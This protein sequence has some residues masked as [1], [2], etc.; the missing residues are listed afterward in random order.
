MTVL[1]CVEELVALLSKGILDTPPLLSNTRSHGHPLLPLSSIHVVL[2]DLWCRTGIGLLRKRF[3][4]SQSCQC[5]RERRSKRATRRLM[6][7]RRDLDRTPWRT[8]VS[9]CGAHNA[10]MIRGSCAAASVAAR[11]FSPHCPPFFFLNLPLHSD[12]L[13]QV[14]FGKHN[15]TELLRCDG[16]DSEYHTSCLTPPLD[17]PPDGAWFCD[18]CLANPHLQRSVLLEMERQKSL[19]TPSSSDGGDVPKRRG[20]GRPPGSTRA[21]KQTTTKERIK[22]SAR[23]KASTVEPK[24]KSSSISGSRSSSAPLD[25]SS[26]KSALPSAQPQLEVP[27]KR[28]RSSTAD[29]ADTHEPIRPLKRRQSFS[30]SATNPP[31]TQPAFAPM[32]L[33]NTLQSFQ[34]LL[35]Y[36][37]GASRGQQ[38]S[39]RETARVDVATTQVSIF[40]EWAP[41]KDLKKLLEDLMQCRT[42]LLNRSY[43]TPCVCLSTLCLS[44]SVSVTLSGSRMEAADP[45]RFTEID[46]SR[47]TSLGTAKKK[48][49]LGAISGAIAGNVPS[50]PSSAS[51]RDR[52]WSFS[53]EEDS[54]DAADFH[55]A[56]GATAA[57]L[58]LP[59]GKSFFPGSAPPNSDSGRSMLVPRSLKDSSVPSPS[60]RTK[61]TS[62]AKYYNEKHSQPQSGPG[63]GP[64]RYPFAASASA[65]AEGLHGSPSLPNRAILGPAAAS[66]PSPSRANKQRASLAQ[67]SE[68]QRQLKY[69]ALQ[70][71]PLQ[72]QHQQ[73]GS[74]YSS[75]PRIVP[76]SASSPRSSSVSASQVAPGGAGG[77]GGGAAGGPSPQSLEDYIRFSVLVSLSQQDVTAQQSPLSAP[78]PPPAD[79]DSRFLAHGSPSFGPHEGLLL[80]SGTAPNRGFVPMSGS[81]SGGTSRVNMI[82]PSPA[83]IPQRAIVAASP[84]HVPP[85]PPSSAPVPLLPHSSATPS[86]APAPCPASPPN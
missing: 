26:S 86:L 81:G 37:G 24:A 60:K 63:P 65:S 56:P 78:L 51:D 23:E 61:Q 17:K 72:H 19:S 43:S 36:G 6:E 75:A 32:N 76:T 67:M 31:Q 48:R 70:S 34:F 50:S 79:A 3:R 41:S 66:G 83:E 84:P 57:L 55:P 29:T 14:C 4:R 44:L 82:L 7:S 38:L 49:K 47:F 46:L 59:T 42:D 21:P 5:R 77:G 12:A 85:Q 80:S 73:G 16:C 54:D 13:R 69:P 74:N 9:L 58:D 33:E 25:S 18:F 11:F 20:R 2:G 35:D 52:S 10:S 27:L 39:L 30:A 8:R 15:P 71:Q 62:V 28:E 1:L 40:K 68:K 53:G 45:E 22:E 64:P